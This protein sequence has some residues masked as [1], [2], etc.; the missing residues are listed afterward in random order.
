MSEVKAGA[1]WTIHSVELILR[2]HQESRVSQILI[3]ITVKVV[4]MTVKAE[5]ESRCFI[6]QV[7]EFGFVL[8]EMSC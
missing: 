7:K 5:E 4:P 3:L 2:L 1:N 6:S 8:Q